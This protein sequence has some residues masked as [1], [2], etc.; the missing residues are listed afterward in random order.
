MR[1]LCIGDALVDLVCERQVS[2]LGEAEAFARHPGGATANACVAAARLGADVALAGGAGD[3][4]WGR[5]LRDS[6]AAEGVTTDW[7]ELVAG[8]PTAVALVTVDRA[9]EPSYLVHG[10][11]VP[12][13]LDLPVAVDACGALAFASNALADDGVRAATLAAREQALGAGKP[14]VVDANLRLHRWGN[15]GRAATELRACLPG[16]FLVKANRA[17]AKMLS[18]EDDPLRAAE[19][20]LAGGARNVIVTLGADGALLRGEL[21]GRA[22][23]V[24]AA[25]LNTAGAGDAFLGVLL[26]RL[27]QADYY[28]S[29]LAAALAEATAEAARATERWPST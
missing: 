5:W 27:G 17:E 24:P 29:V 20:L 15:P 7:F 28:P 9:G 14:V 21:R 18:G 16:A 2:G 12:R 23:G 26:A 11:V 1:T 8:Q 3:D 22:P 10:G 4:P 19:G 6:L 13:L 25:V